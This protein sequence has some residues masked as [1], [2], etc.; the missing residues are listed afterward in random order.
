LRRRRRP[1]TRITKR[2]NTFDPNITFQRK[3]ESGNGK[4]Y[5]KFLFWIVVVA[6]VSYYAYN[7]WY[8]PGDGTETVTLDSSNIESTET[9]QDTIKE[10]VFKQ[11][12]IQIEV[13]NGCGKPGIA[14]IF[15]SHLRQQ[16]FDVL[17]IENYRIMGKISWNVPNSKVIDQVGNIEFAEAVAKSLGIDNK[18]VTSNDNPSPVYDVSVVIGK[19]F[20]KLKGFKEFSK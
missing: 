11:Q 12:K 3:Q 2:N 18:H 14:K 8:L 5:L 15:E 9:A 16:G 13:L 17:N 1:P 20:D 10:P 4:K 6:A 19:D 7:N